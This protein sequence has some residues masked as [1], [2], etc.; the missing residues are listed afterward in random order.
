MH[1]KNLPYCGGINAPFGGL[2]FLLL[3]CFVFNF[4]DM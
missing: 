3:F 4:L 2:G 1:E